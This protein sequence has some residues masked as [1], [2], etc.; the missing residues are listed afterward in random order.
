[1]RL[2]ACTFALAF[3]LL[4]CEQKRE[5]IE[6]SG[7]AMGTTWRATIL[8]QTS[9][10]QDAN[11]S[12]L[13]TNR[14]E[15]LEA[16]F[17]NWR[18][19][20][21]VSRFNDSRST[22]WQN[23]PRELAEVVQFAREI[24]AQTQGSFDITLG[25]L[26]DLWGFGAKGRLHQVPAPETF[27]AARKRCGWE[28]VEV[29]ME[30]PMLRKTQPDVEIN[31]S[32]LVEGYAA[33]DVSKRLKELGYKNFLLDIGGELL[34][35]GQKRDGSAWKAGI[36]QPDEDKGVIT[37]AIELKN[38]ALATSGTYRQFFEVE[39]KSYSHVLDG[40]TGRPVEK[41]LVSVSVKSPSCFFA[42]AWATALLSLGPD[43][44][45]AL[46]EKLGI[47]VFFI[48]HP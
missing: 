23:V 18:K 12:K 48:A 3:A 44:G 30:P 24:S 46:A 29:K 39:G 2:L 16:I 40:R 38:E 19:E 25:P 41:R 37:A 27:E 43:E 31:V 6:C 17:T 1:M 22:E 34:G 26:I 47:P 9:S 8:P 21:P 4:G 13:I 14:L 11:V 36:Q 42:D 20:S 5:T 10:A 7:Q 35:Q 45:K 33:D 32:A 15:E 28:K